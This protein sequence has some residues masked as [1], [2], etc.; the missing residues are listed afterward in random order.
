[1]KQIQEILQSIVSLFPKDN[2]SSYDLEQSNLCEPISG[3]I[4]DK[5]YSRIF[6][7]FL[8]YIIVG[9]LFSELLWPLLFYCAVLLF[10]LHYIFSSKFLLYI[11]G[12]N[13]F[14]ISCC[15]A[16]VFQTRCFNAMGFRRIKKSELEYIPHEPQW[17]KKRLF[18]IPFLF[19][20]G[21]LTVIYMCYDMGN[22]LNIFG[23]L[24]YIPYEYFGYSSFSDYFHAQSL[25]F[26]KNTEHI[27]ILLYS[28]IFIYFISY[29][30]LFNI[31][32]P[33]KL[34]IAIQLFI[35][36]QER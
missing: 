28:S 24:G 32:L 22:I 17:T 26:S 29:I 7:S 11:V 3:L 34:I 6:S 18:S 30:F 8:L 5:N 16:V 20:F 4:L 23:G 21:V 14:L 2:S 10:G 35:W 13:H 27:T 15:C 9:S 12:L 19:C 33:Y 36:K 31:L 25:I 1:M